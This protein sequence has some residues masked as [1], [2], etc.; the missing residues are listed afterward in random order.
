MKE[1]GM[2]VL[3]IGEKNADLCDIRPQWFSRIMFNLQ[4][5]LGFIKVGDNPE[6]LGEEGTLANQEKGD[7]YAGEMFCKVMAVL[8]R[9][10]AAPTY[11]P[12][13]YCI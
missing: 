6:R 7:H 12:S 1:C 5:T 13:K 11:M 2:R 9:F 4:L 3:I 8:I 10:K